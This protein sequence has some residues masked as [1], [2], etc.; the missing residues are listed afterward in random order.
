MPCIGNPT[1]MGSSTNGCLRWLLRTA[2]LLPIVQW[3]EPVLD[4][5]LKKRFPCLLQ[6][7]VAIIVIVVFVVKK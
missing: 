5:Y 4:E 2:L 1:K 3:Y 6:I 7:I